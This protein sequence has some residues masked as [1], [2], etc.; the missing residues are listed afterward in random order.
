MI[1]S[2]TDQ[3]YGLP[4]FVDEG[5]AWYIGCQSPNCRCQDEL[6]NAKME[7]C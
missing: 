5:G 3:I 1:T 4:D 2:S 7:R 6:G